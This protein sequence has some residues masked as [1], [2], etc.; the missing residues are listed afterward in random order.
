MPAQIL[1]LMLLALPASAFADSCVFSVNSAEPVMT[2]S[3]NG[4]KTKSASAHDLKVADD[5]SLQLQST[6]IKFFSDRGYVLVQCMS[7]EF[8]CVVKKVETTSSRL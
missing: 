6:A 8:R 5:D 4:E 3:C 2:Y 7:T 1:T